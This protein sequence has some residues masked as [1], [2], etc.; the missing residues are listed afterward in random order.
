MSNGAAL[1]RLERLLA[2]AERTIA[3]IDRCRPLNTRTELER[4]ESAWK[5]GV[6]A[7]PAWSYKN[8]PDLSATR[9]ALEH[10]VRFGA[11]L[12]GL[13]ALYAERAEELDREASI[14]E[15]LCTE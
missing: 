10:A 6:P 8:V 3:L 12:G 5:S 11:E 7:T 9:K 15:A 13:G 4:L 1:D 2:A 14:V